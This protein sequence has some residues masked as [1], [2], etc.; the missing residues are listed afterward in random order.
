MSAPAVTKLPVPTSYPSGQATGWLPGELS[1][2]GRDQARELGER[3]RDADAVFSS[4]LGRVPDLKSNWG[5][6]YSTV[7]TVFVPTLRYAGVKEETLHKI[8][9]D[10]PRRFLAFVPKT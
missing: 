8:V 4:D 2:D 5:A 7:L 1:P 10:N 3:R 9:V 6:A